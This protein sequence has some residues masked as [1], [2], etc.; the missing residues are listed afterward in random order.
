M[1]AGIF[2]CHFN[3]FHL[4]FHLLFLFFILG[5]CPHKFQVPPH[6]IHINPQL[7]LTFDQNCAGQLGLSCSSSVAALLGCDPDD[8][9]DLR[10]GWKLEELLRVIKLSFLICSLFQVMPCY[11]FSLAE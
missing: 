7:K 3:T 10:S 9:G 6:H 2:C 4:F 8:T 5:L 11:I 1:S